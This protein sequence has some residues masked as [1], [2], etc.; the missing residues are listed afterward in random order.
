[1]EHYFI[2]ADIGGTT[3]KL[4]FIREDGEITKKWEIPTNTEKKGESIPADIAESI[5][6][7][8]EED[9]MDKELIL[10]IGAG[11]PGFVD[12]KTGYIHEAVNIGWKDFNFGPLLSDLTGFPVW[13]D[14]DANLAALGENW[15]GAGKGCTELIAVTLGTGVG[16]GII[17]NG[18]VLNGANGTAAEL[19]HV[20]VIPEGGA[21]CNCGKTGCL[22]TVSSATGIVRRGKEMIGDY[23]ESTLH[24]HIKTG[25]LTAK[26][27]FEASK[28]GDEAAKQVI[29]EV[30]DVLGMAIANM[31]IAINPEKIVIGGGV[32]KAGDWLLEPL[33]KSYRK[34]ALSRTAEASTFGIAELGNDAGVIGGAYL[35]KKNR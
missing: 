1:M 7:K 29:N 34:Y 19:G 13:V 14:N 28:A 27:V 2:G 9:R 25:A 12:T 23:P 20:T 4:A 11:A 32:S 10:G 30:T 22:E 24:P 16:G 5:T 31:A 35:V 21:P 18:Q 33:E 8:M 15:L 3:V 17:A 6:E 26:D